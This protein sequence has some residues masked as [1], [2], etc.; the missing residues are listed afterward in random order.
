MRHLLRNRVHSG[1]KTQALGRD[2]SLNTDSTTQTYRYKIQELGLSVIFFGLCY[3][4]TT[5]LIT[6]YISYYDICLKDLLCGL[7]HHFKISQL[8]S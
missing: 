3:T 7:E 8:R 6:Y 5:Y 1:G 2:M 4:S